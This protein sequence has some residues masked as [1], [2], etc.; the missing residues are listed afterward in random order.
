[1]A[2]PARLVL[3][4]V[5][6]AARGVSGELRVK[7]FTA[8]PQAIGLY[9]ALTDKSGTRVFHFEA[10]RAQGE[11]MLAVRLS[12]V[13]TREAAEALTGVEL[14]ARRDQLPPPATDEFYYDDLVGLAA[15][16]R[17]GLNLG[18]VVSLRNHGAGDIVEIAPEAGGETLLL[19]F[20]K[21]VVVEIDF[22]GGRIIV[23]PPREIEGEPGEA[24]APDAQKTLRT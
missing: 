24:D 4:G 20:S 13:T 18:R 17:A 7:S 12:G 3:L 11:D 6:G 9:G 8:E 15:V 19:P 21:A 23:E 16:T 22:A 10:V 1:V 14:Y 5:F 2:S